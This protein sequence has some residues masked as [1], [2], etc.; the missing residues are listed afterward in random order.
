MRSDPKPPDGGPWTAFDYLYRDAGNFKARN[1][2]LLRGTLSQSQQDQI[3]SRMD[4]S[5]LFVAEQVGIPPLHAALWELSG[6]PT[7]ED[8]GW[9][10][11]EGFRDIEHP[12]E[13]LL[14]Q[15]WG[16]AGD[17]HARFLAVDEWDLRL[18]PNCYA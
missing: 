4:S 16:L 1:C 14:R 6:G 10:S 3:I 2:I 7:N 8:H 5:E 18:S 11:F 9:H 17:F 15:L 13:T 12:S